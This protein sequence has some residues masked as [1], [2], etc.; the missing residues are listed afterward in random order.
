MRLVAFDVGNKSNSTGIT[1]NRNI[2][3]PFSTT[4]TL[5]FTIAS[6]AHVTL[7]VL[8]LLGRVVAT[9]IDGDVERGE[10][11]SRFDG[12]SLPSGAYLCQLLVISPDGSRQMRT[13]PIRITH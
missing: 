13:M 12:S 10:H 4:T 5:Q 2:P 1:L 8:D 9:V 7:K 3:N 11:S 6:R